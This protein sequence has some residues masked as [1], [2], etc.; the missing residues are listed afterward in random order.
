MDEDHEVAAEVAK[1]NSNI[2][3]LPSLAE[4]HG[5]PKLLEQWLEMAQRE[6]ITE[7]TIIGRSS[8]G[9]WFT[10]S[11][12]TDNI[13]ELIGELELA[14]SR[15]VKRMIFSSSEDPEEKG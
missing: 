14:K 3:V 15:I 7:V 13:A 1:A 9:E 4:Q 11:S 2:R 5:V 10:Q 8:S 12:G 6:K